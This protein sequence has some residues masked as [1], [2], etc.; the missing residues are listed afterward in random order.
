ML[1]G[2]MGTISDEAVCI[3]RWDFSETSQTVSLLTRRHG[4]LRGLAKGAKREKSTFSGGFDLLH[5]GN[6]V[7]IVKPGR[8]LAT[9]TEW[10]LIAPCWAVRKSLA[11]NRVGLYVVDLVHHML[12]D[13]DP[14]PGLYEALMDMLDALDADA[15]AINLALLRFQWTLLR[16]CGY[17]PELAHDAQ[18]GE[19]LP[20]GGT[21]AFSPQA[22][23]V[24]A[25]TGG[26]DRWRVRRATIDALQAIVGGE[27]ER[28]KISPAAIDRANRLLAAYLRELMGQELATMAWLTGTDLGGR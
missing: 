21:L 10:H 19:T 17:Q 24:V 6:I 1:W 28:K 8:D 22:G 9:L 15:P 5:R 16:E 27:S 23:G 11:A 25:D 13:A 26:P 12:T 3:R 20:A 14:H 18:N 7:A 2:S 4:V